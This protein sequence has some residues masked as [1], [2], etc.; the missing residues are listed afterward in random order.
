MK[1]AIEK[2]F[3][4][5]IIPAY[6]SGKTLSMCL[7]SIENQSFQNFEIIIV[8]GLSCDDTVFIVKRFKEINPNIH[9]V[10]EK[11]NGIYE[12]MN[13][14]VKMA[15]GHWLYI[16]GSDDTMNSNHVLQQVYSLDK[17]DHMVV[18]GNAKIK[19]NTSWA[20]DGDV[21]DGKFDLQKLLEKNICQQAMFYHKS[22]FTNQTSPFNNDYGICADWDFNLRCWSKKEFLF[23][24]I[25]IVDFHGGGASTQRKANQEFYDD[26]DKNTSKYFGNNVLKRQSKNISSVPMTTRFQ[27][28]NIEIRHWLKRVIKVHE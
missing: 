10:S 8:D 7:E 25:T 13:K 5:I 27:K 21:Y 6:N 14:G 17:S 4:S 20:K 28:F 16:L 1:S 22:C 19:G 12:A 2:P 9:W 24:D 23:I 26:F 15:K 11:D 3:F 18:Y